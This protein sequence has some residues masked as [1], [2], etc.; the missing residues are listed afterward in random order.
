MSYEHITVVALSWTCFVAAAV[1]RRWTQ[2]GP[3]MGD[4]AD[5]SSAW[6]AVLTSFPLTFIAFVW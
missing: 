4:D 2:P 5:D 6:G 3:S 1:R